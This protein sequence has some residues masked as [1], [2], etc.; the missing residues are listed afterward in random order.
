MNLLQYI[1]R[2]RG[3]IK[4]ITSNCTYCGTCQK[5]C[6]FKA[7][8]VDKTDKKWLID[9]EKCHGCKRCIKK[10]PGKALVQIKNQS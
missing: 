9:Y 3:D 6:W 4:W 1:L 2:K 5:I 7:I 8:I 10:C